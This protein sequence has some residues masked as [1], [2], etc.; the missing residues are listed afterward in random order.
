MLEDEAARFERERL[1]ARGYRINDRRFAEIRDFFSEDYLCEEFSY[2][3]NYVAYSGAEHSQSPKLP[4]I[5]KL[6]NLITKRGAVILGST[7]GHQHTQCENNDSR[8]FQEIYEFHGYGAMFIRRN[9]DAA[10]YLLRPGEK[11]VAGIQ[12]SMT[13]FNLDCKPLVTLDYANPKMNSSTKNLEKVFKTCLFFKFKIGD[14]EKG[15]LEVCVNESY[16]LGQLRE[17]ARPVR[18]IIHAGGLGDSLYK[19]ISENSGIFNEMGIKVIAGGNIPQDLA[20][21][22]SKPLPD[23]AREQN[24]TLLE[25]LKM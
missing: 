10:L 18:A 13:I 5:T 22:L 3:D 4:N 1:R 17:A 7:F 8:R 21:A 12:D 16:I 20:K 6:P 25:I 15:S 14:D 2:P 9:S 24:K 19:S 23:L 11:V